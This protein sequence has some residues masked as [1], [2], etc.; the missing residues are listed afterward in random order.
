QEY[1]MNRAVKA[2]RNFLVEDLSKFYMKMAKD[3]VAEGGSSGE[4]ALYAI[5]VAVL[6]S[7]RMFSVASPFLPEFI[8][9][10]FFRKYEKE[11]SISLMLIEDASASEIDP[12]LEKQ[13]EYVRVIVASFLE[14]RQAQKVRLR[15]PL[16]EAYVQTSSQEVAEAV[17]GLSHILQKM[18]NVKKVSAGD[19]ESTFP[20][21][22]FPLGRVC[23]DCEV[24]EELY[25]E[26]IL[27][28]VCRRIQ[29]L[30]KE[31]M[32]VEKD[33]ISVK[34]DAEKEISSIIEK[35]KKE[36]MDS[37]N[38]SSLEFAALKDDRGSKSWEIDGRE[39]RISIQKKSRKKE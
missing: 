32:L 12:L 21:A 3:R 6:S 22:P 20:S 14:L 34:I 4:A 25:E 28:E 39:V 5:Y 35:R 1:E 29:M 23:L 37:T 8:Y 30:R 11:D 13:F 26:A 24:S 18:V 15:W 17:S 10:K 27:N 16:A 2:L 31:G 33:A 38:S 36:L 9:Q 7:L 19:A